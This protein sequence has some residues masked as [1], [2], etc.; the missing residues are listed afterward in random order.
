M[1]SGTAE[2]GALVKLFVDGSG[3]AI[4]STFVD[5]KG[6]WSTRL[7]SLLSGLHKVV[8][9]QTDVAGNIS[10]PSVET[11]FTID[12]SVLG[13]PAL[14]LTS[15]SGKLGDSIT[16]ITRPTLTGAGATADGR[17]DVYSGLDFLGTVTADS[18]GIWSFSPE[19]TNGNYRISVKDV[20]AGKTSTVFDLKIDNIIIL[21]LVIE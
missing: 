21:W 1:I 9:V 19:L 11:T 6:V 20:S 18:S 14:A 13:Q 10:R 7:T 4:A 15:D 17:I 16:N 3:V 5:S 8:A 12:T 2:A